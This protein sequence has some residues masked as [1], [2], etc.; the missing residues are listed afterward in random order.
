MNHINL[1]TEQLHVEPVGMSTHL[2]LTMQTWRRF[3]WSARLR[4][5]RRRIHNELSRY[6]AGLVDIKA[7]A[8]KTTGVFKTEHDNLEKVIVQLAYTL[9]DYRDGV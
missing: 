6:Y 1:K 7:R 4:S 3:R 8:L 5:E 2:R 9:E